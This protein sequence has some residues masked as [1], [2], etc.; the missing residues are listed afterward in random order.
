MPVVY[1]KNPILIFWF[2][3]NKLKFLYYKNQFGKIGKGSKI[4]KQILLTNKK[5]IRLGLNVVLMPN[6]RIELI[7]NYAGE[8]FKPE[9][10]VGNYSQIHQNCHITCAEKIEIGNNVV[11][12]SNVTITDII[13][14]HEDVSIPINKAK[15]KTFPVKIEDEVYIYNNSVILPGVSIGKHSI[16]GANSVVNKNVPPYSIVAGNP[17]IVIKKYNFDTKTW[18]RVNDA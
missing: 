7:T 15:I 11:V 17:A 3:V 10:I 6:S 1:F 5:S 12:V 4:Y 16:I 8:S 9:F 14:P 18:D 2:I 13:H